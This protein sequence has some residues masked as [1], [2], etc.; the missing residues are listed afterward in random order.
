MGS[1]FFAILDPAPNRW[2][3]IAM[4]PDLPIPTV[5]AQEL[6]QALGLQAHPEGGFFEI[7]TGLKPR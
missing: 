1:K 2:D 4:A 5:A 7:L 6:I 3:K